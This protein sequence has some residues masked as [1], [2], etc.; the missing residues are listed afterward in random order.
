MKYGRA[1][2]VARTAKDIKQKVLAE[3]ADINVNYLSLIEKEHRTPSIQMLEK[4][5]KALEVPL[6]ILML[7][8]A[9]KEDFAGVQPH[10]ATLVASVLTDLVL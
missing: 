2:R 9:D 6:P 4:I 1:I 10:V 5:A 3:R 7:L 8:A